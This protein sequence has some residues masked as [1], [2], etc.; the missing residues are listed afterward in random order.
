MKVAWLIFGIIIGAS[1]YPVI[2]EAVEYYGKFPPT[3]AFQE[4]EI[5]NNATGVD[6]TINQTFINATSYKDKLFIVTDGSIEAWFVE[7]P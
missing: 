3:P 5:D 7:Y 1:L 6:L 2:V 4:F